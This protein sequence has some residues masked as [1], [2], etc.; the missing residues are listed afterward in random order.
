MNKTYRTRVLFPSRC[1]DFFLN[2]GTLDGTVDYAQV[3]APAHPLIGLLRYCMLLKIYILYC[4]NVFSFYER[5]DK[6]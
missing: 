6:D 3:D 1:I 4:M 5:N 2:N